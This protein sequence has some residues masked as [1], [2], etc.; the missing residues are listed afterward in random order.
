MKIETLDEK[1]EQKPQN[2]EQKKKGAFVDPFMDDPRIKNPLADTPVIHRYLANQKIIEELSKNHILEVYNE[3]LIAAS[4][5]ANRSPE[6]SLDFMVTDIPPFKEAEDEIY[7]TSLWCLSKLH[8]R[9]PDMIIIAYTIAPNSICQRCLAEKIVDYV[10]LRKDYNTS[11]GIC[12]LKK[13]I[14]DGQN[15]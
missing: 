13:L 8:R 4:C 12:K 6:F 14:E 11:A 1:T 9:L 5:I 2:P 15:A 10:V 7:S 3:L